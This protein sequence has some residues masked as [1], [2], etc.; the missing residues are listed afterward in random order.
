M[1]YGVHSGSVEKAKTFWIKEKGKKGY[2]EVITDDEGNTHY[3][4]WDNKIATHNKANNTLTIF[5]AGWQTKT[6]RDRLNAILQEK[7]LGFI[8]QDKGK[9]LLNYGG[10][11]FEWSGKETYD[12]ANP[13]RLLKPLDK[14]KFMVEAKGQQ[15]ET[16][17]FIDKVFKDI[18]KGEEDSQFIET[19]V[20]KFYNPNY[21]FRGSKNEGI[22][23]I[24][25]T[26]SLKKYLKQ[27]QD[28][29]DE[30]GHY[31]ENN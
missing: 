27:P 5:D 18:E 23:K 20:H 26:F 25:I 30:I 16:K 17:A 19:I 28:V 10:K 29:Q 12:L 3:F 24:A 1:V 22:D 15:K 14:G 13:E 21:I 7:N 8:S 31:G 2:D 11:E 4:L 6:T 9:W